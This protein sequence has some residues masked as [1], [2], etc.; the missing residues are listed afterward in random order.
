[1]PEKAPAGVL[2]RSIIQSSG[3]TPELPR[4]DDFS[5]SIH[6]V[7]GR[8][9]PQSATRTISFH[10]STIRLW[11]V[12]ISPKTALNAGQRR[13]DRFG[14]VGRKPESEVMPTGRSLRSAVEIFRKIAYKP[15][16]A[17]RGAGSEGAD[18]GKQA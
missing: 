1:M 8:G 15:G 2:S 7:L 4:W 9:R 3:Q 17:R 16:V 5:A 10:D 6:L 14:S 12:H 18:H 11:C 13:V